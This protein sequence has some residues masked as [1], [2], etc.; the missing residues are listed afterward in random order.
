[1]IVSLRLLYLIFDRIL[2]WMTLHGR[3]PS[4]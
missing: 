1:M 3:T 4:S 2:T